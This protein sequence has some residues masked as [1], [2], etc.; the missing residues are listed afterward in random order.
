M[1]HLRKMR[2]VDKGDF[3]YCTPR[4]VP[5]GTSY[6]ILVDTIVFLTFVMI[7]WTLKLLGVVFISEI[8]L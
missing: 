2:Y 6:V 7:H 4:S 3:L 8:T 5:F 1:E